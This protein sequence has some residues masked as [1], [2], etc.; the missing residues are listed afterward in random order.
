MDNLEVKKML[1][2]CYLSIDFFRRKAIKEPKT[3]EEDKLKT[4]G[5]IHAM[6]MSDII[7]P[8][9]FT[10]MINLLWSDIKALGEYAH[11]KAGF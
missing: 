7:K 11:G 8:Q 1:K 6:A 9:E 5:I 10:F 3:R 2:G 4:A